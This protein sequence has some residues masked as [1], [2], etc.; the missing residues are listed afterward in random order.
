[1]N[2]GKVLVSL[3]FDDALEAHLDNAMPALEVHGLH[4]T[5]YL[6]LGSPA[7]AARQRDWVAAAKRG[8]ELGNHTIFHPGVST[9]VWV[10]P[11]IALEHYNLDRMRQELAVANRWLQALD[12]R[13]RRSFA[14]PCSNPWLGEHGWPRR[15][16]ARLGLDRTRVAGWI[17]RSGLDFGSRRLDYT[18]VARELFV[19]ARCGG[20]A[21]DSLP[22]LP[23]D[24]HRVRAVDG[25]GADLSSLR[26]AL[27][28]A[29]GRTRWA[30]F[31]FHGVGGGHRLNVE[32]ETFASFCADLANDPRVEV[33][34]FIDAAL[35]L[36]AKEPRLA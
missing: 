23:E 5:F 28:T 27:E 6:N 22:A 35:R 4:G 10:T 15:L 12:G 8:H 3:T 7:F 29:V 14:F 9:K 31:V 17:D 1:M 26:S 33:L 20:I 25:D 36:G 18:P 16:L 32:R 11:G 21:P 2:V 13:E 24:W 34:P 30:V 19:A